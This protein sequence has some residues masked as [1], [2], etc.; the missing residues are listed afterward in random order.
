MDP[1]TFLR[2][3][4]LA[5]PRIGSRAYNAAHTYTAPLALGAMGAWTDARVLLLVSLIWVAHIGA[6]RLVGYGLKYDSG[7]KDTHLSIR[8]A[9]VVAPADADEESTIG[10]PLS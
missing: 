8:P 6:D 9:S 1:R 10:R 3:E 4:G 2:I 7:F 5:G